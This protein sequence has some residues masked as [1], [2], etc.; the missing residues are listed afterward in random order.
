MEFEE[1]KESEQRWRIDLLKNQNHGFVICTT[2]ARLR[3]QREGKWR[4]E[5]TK[6]E[7]IYQEKKGRKREVEEKS[8]LKG[9]LF[10][11]IYKSL[12]RKRTQTG[13]VTV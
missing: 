9:I 13:E 3:D 4:E 2:T 5:R 6:L 11:R 1:E 10:K 12:R 8:R 7:S